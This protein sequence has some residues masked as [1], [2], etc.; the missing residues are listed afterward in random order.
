MEAL[1]LMIPCSSVEAIS[2][3]LLGLLNHLEG[4]MR[5]L[6]GR[7]RLCCV[8]QPMDAGV[9]HCI[10]VLCVHIIAH[11]LTHPDHME[12]CHLLLDVLFKVDPEN[13]VFG[14]DLDAKLH[15]IAWHRPSKLSAD[16]CRNA[17]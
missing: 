10:S 6:T 17:C 15:Q 16:A 3:Q 12:C 11:A 14:P 7:T 8:R 5:M 13:F 2:Q 1:S 4:D 9:P